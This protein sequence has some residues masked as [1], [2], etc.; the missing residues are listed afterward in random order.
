MAQFP[1]GDFVFS[2]KQSGGV[3]FRPER[4]REMACA[5]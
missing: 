5:G 4:V 2:P 1:Y 3:L